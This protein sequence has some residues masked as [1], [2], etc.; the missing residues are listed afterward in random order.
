MVGTHEGL[1]CPALLEES[2]IGVVEFD[3]PGT[4]G[5]LPEV[6]KVSDTPTLREK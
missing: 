1:C 5:T 2:L 3:N 4:E 6:E